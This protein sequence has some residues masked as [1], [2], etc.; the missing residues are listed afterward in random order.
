[1]TTRSQ[2]TMSDDLEWPTKRS[3]RYD[4]C[5]ANPALIDALISGEMVA[6]AAMNIEPLMH[7]CRD[8]AE[9][10]ESVWNRVYPTTSPQ[11]GA[12]EEAKP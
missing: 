11:D 12:G 2:E 3:K 6:V 1:M 8:V 7:A 4:F 5:D 10:Y 9:T